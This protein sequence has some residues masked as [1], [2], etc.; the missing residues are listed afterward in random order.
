[1]KCQHCGYDDQGTH[2][3]AHVCRGAPAAR[4]ELSPIN[5]FAWV[6]VA[7]ERMPRLPFTTDW[8]DGMTKPVRVGWYERHFTDSMSIGILSMQYWDG[9]CWRVRPDGQPHWRQVGDYP[10]WRGLTKAQHKLN[11]DHP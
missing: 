3:M 5:P 9:E 8:F 6:T 7:N 1:V 10:A 2:D 4:V 11:K